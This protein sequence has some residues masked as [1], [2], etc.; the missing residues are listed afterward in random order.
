MA[1]VRRSVKREAVLSLLRSTHSHPSAVWLYER[2]RP[3]FPDLSLGTV[4]RNLRQLEGEGLITSVGVIDG[5]ERFDGDT[6]PHAH[7]VCARCGEVTD[8]E[9]SGTAPLCRQALRSTGGEVSACE[10][11]FTGVCGKCL[12][13]DIQA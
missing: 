10:V 5:V 12:N 1:M 7:F 8:V 13:K 9:I 6:A 2:L 4:Y 11:R 3:R